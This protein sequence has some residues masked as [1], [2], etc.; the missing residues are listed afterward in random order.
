MSCH[1]CAYCSCDCAQPCACART[2]THLMPPLST[3]A[4]KGGSA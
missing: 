1:D 2:C 3:Q 4:T